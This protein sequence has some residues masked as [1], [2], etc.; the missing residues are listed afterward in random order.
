MSDLKQILQKG[1]TSSEK[2]RK[3]E[4]QTEIVTKG[5]RVHVKKSRQGPDQG[6]M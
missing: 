2:L 6:T 1:D 3:T 4:N 5:I